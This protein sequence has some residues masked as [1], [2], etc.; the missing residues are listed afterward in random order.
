M[1]ELLPG[2]ILGTAGHIDHGKTAL[3]R[4]LTGVDTDRL[5][6]EKERG[7]TIELGFAELAVPGRCRFG[8]VDVP[9]HEAFV[10]AMVAG[11]A[12]MD[13]VLLVVAAD[14]GAMPQTREHLA[15][16]ELLA[17]PELVVAVTKCDAVDPEWLDLVDGDVAALLGP[18]RYAGA[19]VVHTSASAGTGLDALVDAL[20][21]AADRVRSS[22]ADDLA[23]L[24][25][26]RVFTIQGTGTVA[27][28]TLWSGR[29]RV[30]ERVRIVPQDLDARVRGLQVHDQ[31]V[32]VAS[33]GERTAVA[34][35]GEGAD[36]GLVARGATLVTSPAWASTW[37]VT[38]R[39]RVLRDA[40][41][42]LAHNQRVHVHHGTAEV[43]ARCALLDGS[44][45]GPG[46][47]GW[48]QL[49]LEEPLAVRARDRFV[50]RAYSP[51]ST[52]GGGEVAEA[53][54][55]K[56]NR[57]DDATRAALGGVLEG[58]PAHAV[59][60][61]LELQGWQGGE[62]VALP[63]QVGL[64]P[65]AVED[66]L[67]EVERRGALRTP[68]AVYA[69]T[70]RRDAEA[71]VLAAVAEGHAEDALRAAVPLAA[72]R[73][74]LPRWAPPDL[75][76][77]LV[78]ALL[79]EGR[80]AA[81][82]GGVRLPAHRPTPSPDQERALERLR[83]I[84]LEGDLG[85]PAVDEMPEELRGRSDLWS[86]LR[87]LETDGFIRPVA[88]GVYLSNEALDGAVARIRAVLGGRRGL[89]PADFRETLPVSRKRLI[90]L[91]NYLDGLGVTV[92]AGDGRDVPASG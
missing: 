12:G 21:A 65:R 58:A 6:E 52:I 37:M 2:V 51:V 36:R 13:V 89:G 73:S 70:V 46:D 81:E 44:E 53:T 86:L 3:V 85:A 42:M 48:V 88:D 34:L 8:V 25:L 26:D 64:T 29:L 80:L 90:P 57:L 92:R 17:V 49:R 20:A 39:V 71:R 69:G 10:R 56:R 23:R 72:V 24:P 22:D 4:A 55:P 11:A 61:H 15:I 9:G 27:T 77:A 76:D 75:A 43:L 91:L 30:G 32:E 60:A 67:P 28:G 84:L 59:E 66:A 33:A 18:T 74:A 19:A 35:A 62:I 63:I 7:I 38:A 50:I 79:A 40:S 14:E 31:E 78:G 87:R 45:L 82:D 41:W 83:A 5:K 68:R 1:V 16:V 47:T 54:P